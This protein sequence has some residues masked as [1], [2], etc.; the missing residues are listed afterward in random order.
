MEKKKAILYI[1]APLNGAW[2][3]ICI[4]IALWLHKSDEFEEITIS[5]VSNYNPFNFFNF[6]LR[7][8]NLSFYITS[9]KLKKLSNFLKF[10]NSK[11]NKISELANF[12]IDKSDQ[13]SLIIGNLKIQ[14]VRVKFSKKKSLLN[15]IT[16]NYRVIMDFLNYFKRSALKRK[17][18]LN[19]KVVNI[20]AGLNVLSEAIRSDYKSYGSIFN[21][22]PGILTS[23]YKLHSFIAEY[24]EISLPKD[25][26]AFVC[27]P[28]QNYIYGFFSRFFSDRGACFV[29]ITSRQQPY[30][31][32]ELKEKNYSSPKI[33][34]IINDVEH[35]DKKKIS[36]YY[37]SRIETPWVTWNYMKPL[38]AKLSSNKKLINL[39]GVS[40]VLYLHSFSDA[41]YA[42]G[43]DGYNDLMDWAI[44]TIS[45]L[46]SNNHV[47]KVIIK[48]HPG[49]N[50]VYYPGDFI[51]NKYL[52]SK[53]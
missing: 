36:D 52:R 9:N 53:F 15:F 2:L 49:I 50:H 26:T 40:V 16:L 22:R 37:K 21:C 48:P 29:E 6:L 1:P 46:N 25:S 39:N 38:E 33:Y 19:Y 51:A 42:F 31:K 14:F 4:D 41:Q 20:Y 18:Y 11:K 27:G 10:S 35:I 7:F 45:L 17:A 47:S 8:K 28:A 3:L 43:Y 12:A 30:I 13:A 34:Q 32:Y 44:S 5:C 24:K 23:L